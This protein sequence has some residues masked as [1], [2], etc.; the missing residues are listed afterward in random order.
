MPSDLQTLSTELHADQ[1]RLRARWYAC[2]TTAN[3]EKRVQEQLEQRS[4]SSFLPIYESVRQ[5]KDRR[6]RLT[7]PLFPGYVFVRLALVDRLRVLQVPS[8]VH[9]VG[10]NGQPAPLDDAEIAGLQNGLASGIVAQP[11]P[12]LTVGRRCQ[13]RTGPLA[14]KRGILLRRKGAL[15][16]VLSL[17]LIMRSVAVDVDEGNIE[18]LADP[19][20][21]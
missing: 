10:F 8:V 12:Y 9:L 16:V 3:H 2:Y 6:K 5:W 19:H 21:S 7:L 1:D 18:P 4:V 15:R 14:G 11:H 20:V 17:E 13:I